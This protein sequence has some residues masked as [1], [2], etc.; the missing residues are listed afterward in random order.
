V[1]G[2]GESIMAI[3]EVPRQEPATTSG[4]SSHTGKFVATFAILGLLAIGQLFTLSKIGTIRESLEAQQTAFQKTMTSQF[5]QQMMAR[6]A[7]I[8]T[9]NAQQIDALRKEIE[10]ASKRSGSAGREL[11]KARAMVA[12]LQKEQRERTEMLQQELAKKA[13]QQQVGAL[14]QDVSSTRTDLDSTKKLLDS[15]RSDLGM[16]RSELGTLIAR[17]HDEIEVLR[18]LGDRDYFEFT[19]TKGQTTQVANVGLL[20]KKTN[21]KRYRFNLVLQVDDMDVEKKDRTVNEPVFFYLKGQKRFY[22]L[23]VNKVDSKTVTGYISTPKGALE[24]A[25]R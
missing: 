13:D 12:D 2:K 11:R 19:A 20:L 16:A 10:D 7:A 22:E 1:P 8:E 5:D 17:N 3:D 4:G 6:S 24:V 23:V 21:P 25:S 18:K 14:S 9:A 15:T